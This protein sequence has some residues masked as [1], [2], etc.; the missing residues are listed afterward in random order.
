MFKFFV[1]RLNS[2]LSMACLE[3]VFENER[4][5]RLVVFAIR[6]PVD[7]HLLPEVH[8]VVVGQNQ[9]HAHRIADVQVGHVVVGDL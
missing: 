3:L 6:G 4:R 1:V 9:V 7:R 2:I 8:P 5:C